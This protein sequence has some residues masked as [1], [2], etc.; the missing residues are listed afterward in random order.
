MACAPTRTLLA[1]SASLRLMTPVYASP[2]QIRGRP[3]TTASDV[4]SLGL[5]LY[6]LLTGRLPY[7]I[8]TRSLHEIERIVC[9]SEPAR[10]S[11]VVNAEEAD[12]SGT[13]EFVNPEGKMARLRRRL[14]GDIDNILTKALQKDPARRFA[15]VDMFIDDLQRHL[16]GLPVRSRP[17]SILYRSG[18]F[19]R[20]NRFAVLAGVLIAVSLSGG[21]VVSVRERERAEQA[22]TEAVQERNRAETQ[23]G[24]ARAQQAF[25]EQK[26][27][28]AFAQEQRAQAAAI[29]ARTQEQIADRRFEDVRRLANSL[30]DIHDLLRSAAGAT[31]VRQ[32]VTSRGLQYLRALDAESSSD[33][34]LQREI[35]AAYEKVG[36]V[37]GDP[38][39]PNLGQSQNAVNS[40]RT[41]L[42]IYEGLIA[43][44]SS[45]HE[46]HRRWWSVFLKLSIKI[47]DAAAPADYYAH[48]EHGLKMARRWGCKKEQMDRTLELW[49]SAEE[50]SQ[51]A[52][53]S[54]FTDT[55]RGV[56]DLL[57]RAIDSNRIAAA[58]QDVWPLLHVMMFAPTSHKTITDGSEANT[59]LVPVLEKAAQADPN[60]DRLR[61][62]LAAGLLLRARFCNRSG[63]S[64][65]AAGLLRRAVN[66]SC[67]VL[68]RSSGHATAAFVLGSAVLDLNGVVSRGELDM[69]IRYIQV[70][71]LEAENDPGNIEGLRILYA[72]LS[73][74]A[75]ILERK[76]D[77]A[78]AAEY[79]KRAIEVAGRLTERAEG[80]RADGTRT[81][82]RE[83][84]Q[85]M[86]FSSRWKAPAQVHALALRYS[87]IQ[88]MNDNEWVA[89]PAIKD[90]YTG[91]AIRFDFEVNRD[92]HLYVIARGTTG[93]WTFLHPQPNESS[94]IRAGQGLRIPSSG[95]FRFDSQPG[96]ETLYV[97][98][99]RQ[100]DARLAELYRGTRDV[101]QA[102]MGDLLLTGTQIATERSGT[103]RVVATDG[104][105]FV[106]SRVADGDSPL[107]TV[108]D[109]RHR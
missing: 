81:T 55:Y 4:Y 29:L 44:R 45:D 94:L 85:G 75:E 53:V 24:Q 23:A 14:E 50:M 18:K 105:D 13:S 2:E 87:V 97:I 91:D 39:G 82:I 65:N 42:R 80:P 27:K 47:N 40:Y 100:P 62:D 70:A 72:R 17:D 95:R 36:D 12:G 103:A 25:A 37:Q 78:G 76:N 49:L 83:L 43:L 93:N 34:S 86:G 38:E 10:A 51:R 58:R 22:A 9:E 59:L 90:F 11:A 5:V 96:I 73:D 92:A 28:E 21:V 109:L 35:A 69:Y 6:E 7:R 52:G 79:R 107:V 71:E 106:V 48:T 89:V 64:A 101:P 16:T 84:F 74:M 41:A 8:N 66:E 77:R 33:A 67:V 108:L 68:R 102:V 61:A 32:L 57:E 1:T 30:F 63:L 46:L 60:D 104:Q 99:M 15:S 98:V 3:V 26:A 31:A 88:R 19:A 20:R 54:E 56:V